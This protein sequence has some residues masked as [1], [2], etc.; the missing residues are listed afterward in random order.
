MDRALQ[1]LERE[2]PRLG[3]LVMLRYFGGL[4]LEETA[5]SLGVSPRTAKRDWTYARAW[6]LEEMTG[7]QE[8]NP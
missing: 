2:H 4:T 6:L 3:E 5:A 7:A 8:E 1:H